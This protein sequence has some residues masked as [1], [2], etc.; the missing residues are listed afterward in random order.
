[1]DNQPNNSIDKFTK[2]R[3][4]ELLEPFKDEEYKKSIIPENIECTNIINNIN[5]TCNTI[6]KIRI[7]RSNTKDCAIIYREL[8]KYI[9]NEV[10][11]SPLMPISYMM[12][13]YNNTIDIILPYEENDFEQL[14]TI[15]KEFIINNLNKD[16]IETLTP[17]EMIQS[18]YKCP[19]DKNIIFSDMI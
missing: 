4:D 13:K 14:C 7:Y 19:D 9:R 8:C 17:I 10:Y 18:Q 11:N 12:D 1:M 16:K 15:L 5:Q 6:L 2:E 3:I